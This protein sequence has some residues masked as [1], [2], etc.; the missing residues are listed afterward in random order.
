MT[1]TELITKL[2]NQPGDLRVFY[3]VTVD[4]SL[5]EYEV[6]TVAIGAADFGQQ[7]NIS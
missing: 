7:V 1:V 2:Q 6:A 3:S 4:G 5:L